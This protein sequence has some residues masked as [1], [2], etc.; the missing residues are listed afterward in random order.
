MSF[1][2]CCYLVYYLG[3]SDFLDIFAFWTDFVLLLL[4]LL[5][6]L[7]VLL[8]LLLLLLLLSL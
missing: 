4:M 7:L 5:L 1:P 8:V 6:L 2:Y 3:K